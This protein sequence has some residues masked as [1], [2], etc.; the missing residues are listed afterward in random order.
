MFVKQD[1][2]ATM[3][4]HVLVISALVKGFLLSA[5]I[6]KKHTKSTHYIV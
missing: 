6:K 1:I 5:K 3:H 2:Y 4:K